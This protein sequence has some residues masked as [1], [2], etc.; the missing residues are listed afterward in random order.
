MAPPPT[1]PGGPGVS[2][3][4]VEV[5]FVVRP[6][7]LEDGALGSL[8]ELQVAVE[9][10]NASKVYQIT[11]GAEQTVA[12]PGAAVFGHR[13]G[14]EHASLGPERVERLVRGAL[15]GQ[16]CA[17]LAYGNTGA[18]KSFAMGLESRG[19]CS[20]HSVA[21]YVS[22]RLFALA[23]GEE[24]ALCAPGSPVAV[25]VAMAEVYSVGSHDRVKDLLK[26]DCPVVGRAGAPLM[27]LSWHAAPDAE[28]VQRYMLAGAEVRCTGAMAANARSSRSHAIFILR[29]RCVTP[30]PR[31]LCWGRLCIRDTKS[32]HCCA[33][34]LCIKDL[35]P[36]AAP[37][38]RRHAPA[39]AVSCG[40]HAR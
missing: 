1:Q 7:I 9:G 14:R 16:S 29:V 13:S 17:I 39:A 28:A 36:S 34:S 38:E 26:V 20:P 11:L 12:L 10:S 8:E 15:Q 25:D 22:R 18:G 4:A 2:P 31:L 21:G 35:R 37:G 3:T 30:W 33:V 23:R 19:G 24:E 40:D 32:L 27:G 5:A 6:P